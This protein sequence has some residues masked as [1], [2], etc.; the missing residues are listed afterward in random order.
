MYNT[1]HISKNLYVHTYQKPEKWYV[2][3]CIYT[4]RYV[5]MYT[6]YIIYIHVTYTNQSL[7]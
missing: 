5:Y 4:Y 2:Y 1:S 3:I 7:E 6:Y